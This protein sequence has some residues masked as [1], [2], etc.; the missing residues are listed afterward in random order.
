[1]MTKKLANEYKNLFDYLEHHKKF[2]EARKPKAKENIK[3]KHVAAETMK[4]LQ[5]SQIHSYIPNLRKSSG[6]NVDKFESLMRSKL[7]D[8]YKRLQGYDRPYISVGELYVCMRQ[9]YYTRLHY[10]IDIKEQ[11]RFAYLY[12]I[13]KIGNEIHSVIQELYDFTETEK[14]VVS[15]KYKAKGRID[16]IRDIYLYEIKSFDLSKFENKY[17]QD[18]YLQANIYAYILNTEYGYNIKKVVLVYVMRDLKTIVPFDLPVNNALAKSH[19][20]RAPLLHAAIEKRETIDPIGATMNHCKYC[21][22][23]KVCKSDKCIDIIQPFEKKAI[24]K[25]GEIKEESPKSAFIL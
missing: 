25:K 6:F 7:I 5:E 10:P 18:H 19:L 9:N 23:M 15:E 14:T 12:L 11:F 1:M 24:K 8:G 2:S 16:G 4:L 20:E 13:Q 17:E 21:S 22:F 3:I